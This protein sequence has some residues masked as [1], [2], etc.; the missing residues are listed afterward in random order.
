[1]LEPARLLIKSLRRS[2][3]LWSGGA[4]LEAQRDRDQAE[5]DQYLRE[6]DVALGERNEY[7][8][9]RDIA[10]GE[11]NEYLRQRDVA[12]GEQNELLRQRDEA[13]GERNEFL[14]QLESAQVECDELR[15]RLSSARWEAGSPRGGHA[16][17]LAIAREHL[18][19]ASS[20]PTDDLPDPGA[21]W[22]TIAAYCREKIPTFQSPVEAVHFAQMPAG[23][24]SFEVRLTGDAL[25]EL[26]AR[27]ERVLAD[28]APGAGAHLQS[29][30]EPDLSLPD[31]LLRHNGRSVS[32]PLGTHT[33]FFFSV[34]MRVP[35]ID[36]VCEIG[37]G[38]G[39]PARL[40]LTNG[41]RRPRLYAILDLPESLFFAEVYLRATY[42]SSLVRYVQPSEQID[43]AEVP[44]GT[45]LLCPVSRRAALAPIRFNV[46]VNTLSLQEMTDAYV[47]FYR[48]WLTEQP[49]DYF[50]SF[51]YLLQSADQ[52]GESP[53]L[54]APRL[55]QHWGIEWTAIGEVQPWC[56]ANVLARREAPE[57]IGARNALAIER[58]FRRPL[59][60]AAVY[61]LLHA[62][63]TEP[64]ARFA[65][66]LMTAMV[67][68]FPDG[69][70]E[71]AFLAQR[72]G[73]LERGRRTLS[74]GELAHVQRVNADL[75]AKLMAGGNPGVPR[76]MIALQRELYPS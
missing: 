11:R 62:A 1:M 9:Q 64:D 56:F 33:F 69:P 41:Y 65:Y 47:A 51:N 30:S 19:S 72:I 36:T 15:L 29:F 76:Q 5:R 58:Y 70:K 48:E 55:S 71:I 40:W 54:F 67:E 60:P 4:E 23:H 63:D 32:T 42:D 46:V 8:R 57:T 2:L 37:G 59:S 45:V 28:V 3:F 73:E 38:Y 53:N 34:A 17:I 20:D 13:M 6:R 7:L 44:A 43:P 68:D 35:S 14:R 50:Y 26:L 22:G 27:Q 49:S 66:R 39:A 16:G 18:E 61:P 75:V 10:L 24:G 12:L 74:D 31:T 21:R 52:R 25:P